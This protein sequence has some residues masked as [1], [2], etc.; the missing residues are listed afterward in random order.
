MYG[1]GVCCCLHETYNVYR[2]L[3]D[4]EPHQNLGMCEVS[5]TYLLRCWKKIHFI[6]SL[7]CLFTNMSLKCDVMGSIPGLIGL[8]YLRAL[9]YYMCRNLNVSETQC[10]HTFKCL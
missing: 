1:N 8:S 9:S 7:A 6:V 5:H 3:V 10:T 2:T 4:N